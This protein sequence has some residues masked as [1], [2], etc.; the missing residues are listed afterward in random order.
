MKCLLIYYRFEFNLKKKKAKQALVSN[1][2]NK[3]NKILFIL[4]TFHPAVA[5]VIFL[6]EQD[7]SCSDFFLLF[8]PHVTLS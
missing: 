6:C 8:F 5:S 7:W 4:L 2:V 1:L 3:I